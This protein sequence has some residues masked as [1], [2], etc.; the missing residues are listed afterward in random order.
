MQDPFGKA[1]DPARQRRWQ[2][3]IPAEWQEIAE[4]AML[5]NEPPYP[6]EI[7]AFTMLTK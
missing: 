7:V 5:D 2:R 3:V 1:F 6:S 4:I